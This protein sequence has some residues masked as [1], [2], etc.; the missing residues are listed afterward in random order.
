MRNLQTSRSY[1]NNEAVSEIRRVFRTHLKKIVAVASS[2]VES[3]HA[4]HMTKNT[5]TRVTLRRTD[6]LTGTGYFHGP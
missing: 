5:V 6:E 1:C 2:A 3:S 4:N